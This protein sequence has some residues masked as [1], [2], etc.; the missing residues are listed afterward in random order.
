MRFLFN[1]LLASAIALGIGL[2]LSYY[3]LTDG[4]VLGA[5]QFGPWLAWPG[6][7]SP[8]PDPYTRAYLARSGIL[9]LGSSEGVQFIA[10]TDSD[11]DPLLSECTYLF[12]GK[13]PVASFWTLVATNTDGT[14]LSRPG[15]P[16]FIDS[17]HLSRAGDG[18]AVVRI[19]PQ[20]SSG[21]WLETVGSGPMQLQ[22]TLYDTS[23]LSG[24]DWVIAEMPTITRET[25]A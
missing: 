3:A 20:L 18:A 9:Q 11:G 14:N 17:M 4:R 2:G 1:L 19:G 15:T 22:L 10:A 7:G 13:T 6:I 8:E 25:C 24:L 21:D 16:S 5:R 23:S 12:D